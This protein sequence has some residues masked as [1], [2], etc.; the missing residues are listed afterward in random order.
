MWIGSANVAVALLAANVASSDSGAATRHV[1]VRDGVL[2]VGDLI[3]RGSTGLP[4][5]VARLVVARLPA[6]RSTLQLSAKTVADLV[7]RRVPGLG[8]VA[9]GSASVR[10]DVISPPAPRTQ[11]HCFVAKAAMSD[12]AVVTRAD[13][14]ETPCQASR[15]ARLRYGGGGLVLANKPVAAGTYLGRLAG[16]PDAAIGKGAALTLRSSAGPVTVERPVVAVQPA[17]SGGRLF[18]RSGSGEIFAAPLDLASERSAR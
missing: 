12:G 7:R 5:Q 14:A 6:G 18:V 17:R 9:M 16:L 13:V 8:P 2:R 15:A 10:I 1:A 11:M 3:D 4:E